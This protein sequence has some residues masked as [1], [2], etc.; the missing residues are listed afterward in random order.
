MT[1]YSFITANAISNAL[2][3][4]ISEDVNISD[5]YLYNIIKELKPS[6]IPSVLSEHIAAM[7]EEER[8]QLTKAANSKKRGM[9]ESSESKAIK[10]IA[11]RKRW[12]EMS[13]QERKEMGLKSKNGISEENKKTQTLAANRAYSPAREKGL[14]KPLTKCPHCGKIGGGPIMKRYH[15]E[16]CKLL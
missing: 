11:Q 9:K 10:S 1:I 3:L 6:K 16:R 8:K 14:K 15:F 7:S 12:A 4:E 13:I 5:Q 2:E